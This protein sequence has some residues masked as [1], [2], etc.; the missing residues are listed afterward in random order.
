MK[1][2]ATVLISIL[3]IASCG[4]G[5]EN[6]PV[7]TT[8]DVSV[9]TL[10]VVMQIGTEFGDST[11][12]FGDIMDA[13]IDDEG[14]ILVLDRIM[15]ELKQYDSDG[16]YVRHIARSGNG[17]GELFMPWDMFRFPD[18]RLMVMDPGKRGF[19]VFD[20][21]LSFV[22][23]IGL[24]QQNQP[25]MSCAISDS[26][27]ASYKA[28][29][30]MTETDLTITRRVAQYTYGSEEWDMLYWSDS[31]TFPLDDVR[32]DRSLL[33]SNIEEPI[34]ICSD[35]SGT[36]FFSLKD[37]DNYSV[38]GWNPMG[39]VILDISFDLEPMEKTSEEMKAESTYV[40]NYVAR[41]GEVQWEFQPNPYRDMVLEIDIGT[42][43]NLWVRTGE[44]SFPFFDL[45]DPES[46]ELVG[47]AVYPAEGFTWNTEVCSNGI[48]A[49]EE[50]P[51][52]GYQ[53]LYVL[54]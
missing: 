52:E 46:G 8:T 24:W 35:Q 4:S 7:E 18:E 43:G 49:W 23:E 20:D 28:S 29:L 30:D 38:T 48:L 19:V 2:C 39:E 10:E 3:L 14:N 22:E 47:H 5:E 6:A 16:N 54:E 50:D 34:T 53:V 36:V 31:L 17:P 15:A 25:F 21:S 1:Y 45:F 32:R 42:D 41:G 13:E 12:T 11:N 37:E 33:F 9:D 40:T 26:Q 27:F 51:P 44:E